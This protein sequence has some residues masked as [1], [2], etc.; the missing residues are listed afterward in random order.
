MEVSVSPLKPAETPD[1]TDT[2]ISALPRDIL[3]GVIW[4]PLVLFTALVHVLCLPS[5]KRSLVGVVLL[6]IPLQWGTHLDLRIGAAEY[7]AIEGFDL[8]LTTVALCGLY[9]GWLFSE[10]ANNSS[11]RV[12]WNWPLTAYTVV[13]MMSVFV[14]SDPELSLFQIYLLLETLLLYFYFAGNIESRGD[15]IFVLR[16]LI[17]G[18]LIESVYIV[19]LAVVG[20]PF[21]FIRSLGMKSVIY[22]PLG[23]GGFIRPGGTIGSP[24][25]AAAYLA[26]TITLAI[27]V[28]Q[29]DIPSSLRRLTIPTV[30]S[31]AVALA[32]TLSRGGWL[33]LLISIAVLRGAGWL[34]GG[35]T[36]KT[37]FAS[38]AA[39][40][41]V[42]LCLYIPNPMSSRLL[43][44]D[45]GS[46]HSRVPLMHLAFRVIS[47]HPLLGVG[48]NNF[49]AVMNDYAGSEFRHEW[50]YTVHNEFLL[51]CSETGLIGLGAYLWIFSSVIRRG[52]RLWRT[53]DALFA[54]LGIGVVGALIGFL[55]HMFVDIFSDAGL[56]QLTWLLV[57]LIAV[58]ERILRQER[59]RCAALPIIGVSKR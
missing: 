38:I 34:R 50:I 32:A 20:H 52:W 29:M 43:S 16:M 19:I 10:R 8:S 13:V 18:A 3:R 9:V 30:A 22:F 27:A 23:S 48:A 2:P 40:I 7:G 56:L 45:N 12:I 44:D 25:Y 5:V 28:R 47:A 53:G 42:A 51:V 17:V 14:S 41:L 4:S 31:C 46:A 6:N 15:V 54:P 33:E 36:R 26:I 39:L 58:C 57:A 24:N 49:A 11:P 55:S 37:I 1:A 21:I 35:V 59:T